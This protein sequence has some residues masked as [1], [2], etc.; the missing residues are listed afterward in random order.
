MIHL[1]TQHWGS[2]IPSETVILMQTSIFQT[3]SSERN[4]HC[5]LVHWDKKIKLAW[6]TLYKNNFSVLEGFKTKDK[7]EKKK[8]KNQTKRKPTQ[9]SWKP[10]FQKKKKKLTTA[11]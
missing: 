3:S 4:V 5:F 1:S 10:L 2:C 8:P 11:C 9:T 7:W 6:K